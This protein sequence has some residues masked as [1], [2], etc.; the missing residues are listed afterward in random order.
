MKPVEHSK[1]SYTIFFVVLALVASVS[2]ALSFP[3]TFYVLSFENIMLKSLLAVPTL[4]FSVL[5][6]INLVLFQFGILS[7]VLVKSVQIKNDKSLLESIIYL[8]GVP[9][10]RAMSFL[11]AQLKVFF[12]RLHGGKVGKN[13]KICHGVKIF[14][15]YFVEIGDNVVIGMF[16][17]I[18]A[19]IEEKGVYT[20]KKVKIGNNVL[21]GGGSWVLPGVLV[22][23][24]VTIGINSVVPKNKH[25]PAGSVWVGQRLRK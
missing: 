25:L 5:L 24:N 19:H 7:Y 3:V 17:V 16:T 21:I 20:L 6:F 18:S 11:P 13:V 15:P 12:I 9:L 10:E 4:L 2:G 8:I 23:D 14:N 22:G 1:T